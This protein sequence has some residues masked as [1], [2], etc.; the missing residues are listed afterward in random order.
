MIQKPFL[1][2]PE[3]PVEGQMELMNTLTQLTTLPE[4]EKTFFAIKKSRLI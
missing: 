1:N 3:S 2:L 4:I